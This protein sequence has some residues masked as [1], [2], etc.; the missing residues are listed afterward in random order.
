MNL[1][2][3]NW[4]NV[5]FE[6]LDKLYRLDHFAFN[7]QRKNLQDIFNFQLTILDS[8][9]NKTEFVDNNKK[10]AVLILKL[11]FKNDQS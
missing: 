10:S 1:N 2:V 7:F 8:D 5:T 11:T 6:D 4:I 3:S 9:A